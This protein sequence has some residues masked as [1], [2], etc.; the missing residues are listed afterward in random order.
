MAARLSTLPPATVN[1][2]GFVL[3]KPPQPP[4]MRGTALFSVGFPYLAYAT[5]SRFGAPNMKGIPVHAVWI[6]EFQGG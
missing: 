1:D 4:Y 2:P 6:A 3:A 5:T